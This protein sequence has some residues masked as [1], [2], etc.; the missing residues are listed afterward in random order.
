V[1]EGISISFVGDAERDGVFDLDL[2]P[3]GVTD[4]K[5]L[6]GEF[7]LDLDRDLLLGF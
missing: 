5:S 3:E 6:V 7:D 4:P 1:L 2:V